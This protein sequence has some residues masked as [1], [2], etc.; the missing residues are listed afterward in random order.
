[1][2]DAEPGGKKYDDPFP[3]LPL[4]REVE[5]TVAQNILR[6]DEEYI[7]QLLQQL[8]NKTIS[9]EDAIKLIEGGGP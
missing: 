3:G 1:V 9:D 8:L 5:R 4:D 7:I 6:Y 2:E